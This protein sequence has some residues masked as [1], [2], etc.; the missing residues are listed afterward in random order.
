MRPVPL[1]TIQAA[2]AR[3]YDTCIVGS[4]PAGLAVALPLAEAGQ[5]VLVLEAGGHAPAP[6]P[7]AILDDPG[8]HMMSADT[9]CQGLGGTSALW[10]G[11]IVPLAAHDFEM[12]G[13]PLPFVDLLPYFA[14]AADFLGGHAPP[15][16]F[17]Q[18]A[19][20]GGFDLDATE[21]LADSG[22]LMRWHQARIEAPGGPDVLLQTNAVGLEFETGAD[23]RPRC[24]HVRVRQQEGSAAFSIRARVTVLAQGGIETARLLLAAQA[25]H[26]V[27]LGHLVALGEYYAGHLTGSIASIVFPPRTDTAQYGWRRGAARGLVRRVFRSTPEAMAEG[28]NMFFWARNGPAANAGHGSGVLSAKHLLARLRGRS[29][30][31]PAPLGPGAPEPL[32]QSLLLAHLRN[33]A[34][35][36]GPSLRALPGLIRARYDRG[37]QA[38]DHLI[39]N[40]ANRYRL[41]YHAEQEPLAANR[42]ELVGPVLPDRLPDIRIRFGFSVS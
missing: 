20:A 39:P 37:R 25:R 32:E 4:G 1:V 11:R 17:L 30:Q 14:E 41:S 42:I 34:T 6:G 2:L 3:H 26:R 31:D 18:P 22:S 38:V 16:P 5:S 10:G 40:G 36:A 12:A 19:A 28:V 15:Q 23:G 29:T 27:G 8:A 33:L 9:H 13:W 21:V 7:G 35:D 24:T